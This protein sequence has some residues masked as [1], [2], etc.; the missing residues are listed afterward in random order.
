MSK[1]VF[2]L[3]SG[4][5]KAIHADMP[6]LRSLGEE[7][8]ER[9]GG[10]RPPH[11][12]DR[13][14]L[15]DFEVWLSV[16]A[17]EQPWRTEEENLEARATFLKITRLMRTVL[18]EHVKE[19]R[20]VPCPEWLLRL[21][22][23]WHRDETTVIT[24]NYDPLVEAAWVEAA[25][26]SAGSWVSSALHTQVYPRP[27][28]PTATVH[29][30]IYGTERVRTFT[31]LKLHGS[32]NWLYSGRS[33]FYGELIYDD[34][35]IGSWE[36]KPSEVYGD[37]AEKVPLIVPPTVGKSGFFENE[38]VRAQ[39]RS[40]FVALW[41]ANRVYCMG[42]SLPQ[43]DLLLKNLLVAGVSAGAQIVPV[44]IMRTTYDR[45]TDVFGA[46]TTDAFITDAEPIPHFVEMYDGGDIDW[47]RS[48]PYLPS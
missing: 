28:M 29:G 38:V 16:L 36:S 2:V 13:L 43:G 44:D 5:S 17:E 37:G 3:G 20:Q 8:I 22:S 9:L 7:V 1:D 34:S 33:N 46:I 12:P 18:A 21:V 19:A 39:W 41:G 42:Y 4:F 14:D 11:V 32:L 35:A 31:L 40:A 10:S 25:R 27:M 45:Y 26:Q 24:L 30:A 15:A 6:L 48:L 47:D 23:R